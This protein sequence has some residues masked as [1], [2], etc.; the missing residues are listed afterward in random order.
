MP[1]V[2]G[3]AMEKIWFRLAREFAAAGHEVTFFFAHLAGFPERE[4]DR[5]DPHG[6]PR[7]AGFDHTSGGFGGISCSISSWGL[8]ASSGDLPRGDVVFCNTISLPGLLS[9]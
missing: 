7:P 5:G 3:G 9:V 4:S 1:P 6:D 2:A 8:A